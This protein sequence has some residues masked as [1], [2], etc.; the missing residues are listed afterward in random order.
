MHA[1]YC[2]CLQSELVKTFTANE[3]TWFPWALVFARD[4]LLSGA[5]LQEGPQSA[6]PNVALF[7]FRAKVSFQI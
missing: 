7:F 3:D 1:W 5:H 6:A 2:S 4:R